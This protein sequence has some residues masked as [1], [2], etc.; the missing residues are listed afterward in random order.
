MKGRRALLPAL[1]RACTLGHSA[2]RRFEPAKR[3][4]ARV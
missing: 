2:P 4:L 1:A 3:V